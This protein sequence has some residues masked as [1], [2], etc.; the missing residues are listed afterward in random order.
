VVVVGDVIVVGDG[1]VVG[2]VGGPA[3]GWSTTTT[4]PT[5]P[6]STCCLDLD[7]GPDLS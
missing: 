3:I 7:L 1:D 6:T 2:V 4:T 5:T